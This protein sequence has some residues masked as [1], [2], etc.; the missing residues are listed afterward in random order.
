MADQ[1]LRMEARSNPITNTSHLVQ[2]I[3]GEIRPKNAVPRPGLP[4]ASVLVNDVDA[5]RAAMDAELARPRRG[6]HPCPAVDFIFA[7]PPPHDGPRAWK[8]E[9]VDAWAETTLAWVRDYC[10]DAPVAAAAVHWDERSPHMHLLLA[11]I[12]REGEKV[13]LGIKAIRK[14]LA[15]G[16]PAP[17]RKRGQHRDELSA[18]QDAYHE[19]VTRRF[20]LGRGNTQSTARHVK[21]DALE[22]TQ[23]RLNDLKGSVEHYDRAMDDVLEQRRDL[24]TAVAELRHEQARLAGARE[25]DEREAGLAQARRALAEKE[26]RKAEEQRKRE[27]GFSGR[28]VVGR[29]ARKGKARR[30]ALEKQVETLEQARDALAEEAG[31]LRT[32][33]NGLEVRATNAEAHNAAADAAM[34]AANDTMRERERLRTRNAALEGRLGAIE[35]G[36]TKLQEREVTAAT[37]EAALDDRERRMEASEGEAR[38]K[39]ERIA[40]EAR[41]Q[42]ACVRRETEA[43][44]QEQARL[45]GE[46]QS[47]REQEAQRLDALRTETAS[48]QQRLHTTR[49][50]ETSAREVL[51]QVHTATSA[52]EREHEE[53]LAFGNPLSRH[54]RALRERSAALEHENAE[55][56]AR[57]QGEDVRRREA[58]MREWEA[59]VQDNIRREQHRLAAEK[60]NADREKERKEKARAQRREEEAARDRARRDREEAERLAK[61]ARQDR[62]RGSK[63]T[64]EGKALRKRL[65]SLEANTRSLE[66]QLQGQR[67]EV[68]R[69]HGQL[70]ER[71]TELAALHTVETER[72][73]LRTR[74]GDQKRHLDTEKQQEYRRGVR[75]AAGAG[76]ALVS[77]YGQGVVQ[78]LKRQGKSPRTSSGLT[79]RLQAVREFL[80]SAKESGA[81]PVN[82]AETLR[83]KLERGESLQPSPAPGVAPEVKSDVEAKPAPAHVPIRRSQGMTMG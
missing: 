49:Q 47:A 13:R 11:P 25:V 55:L 72:D 22:G 73:R 27:Q 62:A 12:A 33:V 75:E 64:R 68:T 79:V 34:A 8:K 43:H 63:R 69:L 77:A 14:R 5:A 38:T 21:V 17:K 9:V 66:A 67:T 28:L 26:A 6:A 29:Q 53:A 37:R 83:Q 20:G 82:E 70:R 19:H 24:N 42:A 60:A 58:L 76:A 32:R 18:V 45:A 78:S 81:V 46:T 59:G 4:A 15:S 31:A 16:V 57:V 71:G 44:R 7:G 39:A 80:A 74:L 36:E 61:E 41:D 40:H 30:E 50:D 1:V 3:L 54:G 56:K 10:P 2:H 52:A 48:A 23:R 35:E 65:E 51:A